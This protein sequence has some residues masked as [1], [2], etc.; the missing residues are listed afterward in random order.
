MAH[1]CACGPL[2]GQGCLLY[3]QAFCFGVS[4]LSHWGWGAVFPSQ[5]QLGSAEESCSG[6]ELQILQMRT[7]VL[8]LFSL[9]LSHNCKYLGWVSSAVLLV[10]PLVWRPASWGSFT[11]LWHK[12][13]ER[14]QKWVDYRERVEI[15]KGSLISLNYFWITALGEKEVEPRIHELT[16]LI[17]HTGLLLIVAF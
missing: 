8:V 13:V 6:A 5:L 10:N 2:R 12:S 9:L 7:E 4:W 11:M 17:K 15:T 14:P 3:M 16:V 1:Q